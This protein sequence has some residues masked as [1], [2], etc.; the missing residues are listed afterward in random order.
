MIR[1]LCLALCL[2]SAAVCA[3]PFPSKPINLIVPYPPGGAVDPIA[4]L[5]AEKISQ[6]WGVPVVVLNRPGAGTTI[7]LNQ[8]AKAEPDGYTVVLATAS[9]TSNA[10]LYRSL[11]YDTLKDF[12]YLSMAG[13]IPLAITANPR[14]PVNSLDELVDRLKQ[15][16]G[17]LTYSSSGNGTIIHLGGELFKSLAGVDMVH[18]PYKGSGPSVMAGVAGEVD[19]T[20]DSVF[21]MGPQVQ[22]GK[23]KYIAVA[24]AK[25]LKSLPEV[26][27]IG[28]KY[29]GYFVT[30][31]VGFMGPAGIPRDIADA[32]AK[33]IARVAALPDVSE[34]LASLGVESVSS[35]PREF[36]SFVESEI[37]KWEKVVHDAQIPPVQ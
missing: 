17:S 11:P 9:I 15:Q 13:M 29:P 33:E 34:R 25:R 10:P 20:F 16:P 12:T 5:Y 28:E 4:R 35:T 18:V 31:W 3:A 22:A 24:S 6:N 14:T 30:S 26:P 23:L 2:F 1:T 27:A 7:G 8:A 37:R 19:L 21:L 32:W 36:S